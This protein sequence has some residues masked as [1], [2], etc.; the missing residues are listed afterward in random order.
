MTTYSETAHK[1]IRDLETL[2]RVKFGDGSIEIV[3][4]AVFELD[5]DWVHEWQELSNE[6]GEVEQAV[7]RYFGVDPSKGWTHKQVLALLAPDPAP[8]AQRRT[9]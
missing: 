6:L 9:P 5:E 7:L 8:E 3:Y 1:I 2:N 4:K